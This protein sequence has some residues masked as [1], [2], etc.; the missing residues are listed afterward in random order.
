[1]ML[2]CLSNTLN[3]QQ[4]AI[5]AIKNSPFILDGTTCGMKF[6][7][8]I[9]G[10]DYISY[11]IIVHKILKG[12]K[13]IHQ[14]DTIELISEMPSDWGFIE[15][16]L[17]YTPTSTKPVSWI[18]GIKLGVKARG[19]Y[20]LKKEIFQNKPVFGLYLN[21]NNGYFGIKNIYKTDENN[22]SISE[23]VIYGFSTEFNSFDSFNIFLKNNGLEEIKE[24]PLEYIKKKSRCTSIKRTKR[25]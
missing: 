11:P 2:G 9:N 19:I 22:M 20:F 5:D 25:K 7:K 8:N 21:Q 4:K 10:K 3:A 18:N 6:L 24:N 17:V 14:G 16:T 23:K 13:S 15:D 12:N 1:M